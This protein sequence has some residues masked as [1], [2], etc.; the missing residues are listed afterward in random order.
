MSLVAS[1]T[2]HGVETKLYVCG[3]KKS[4]PALLPKDVD[5]AVFFLRKQDRSSSAHSLDGYRDYS[6]DNQV[7]LRAEILHVPLLGLNSPPHLLELCEALRTVF[8]TVHA[9]KESGLATA[10]VAFICKSGLN[11]SA[12]VA[13]CTAL[14]ADDVAT[15][16]SVERCVTSFREARPGCFETDKWTLVHALYGLFS[17]R[18]SLVPRA[19][20]L[21]KPTKELRA[22]YWLDLGTGAGASFRRGRGGM[23]RDPSVFLDNVVPETM[24][25]V[26][27]DPSR[28]MLERANLEV[29]LGGELGALEGARDD[30]HSSRSKAHRYAFGVGVEEDALVAAEWSA[31]A[32]EQGWRDRAAFVEGSQDA[33][34]N[35]YSGACGL[36][37]S[38]FS[39][40]FSAR[41]LDLAIWNVAR[42]LVEG[43]LFVVL[44]PDARFLRYVLNHPCIDLRM[45]APCSPVGSSRGAAAGMLV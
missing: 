30:K 34:P 17:D 35:T 19:R 9:R 22:L 28:A 21:W 36:V 31:R 3:I 6:R 26:G 7:L 14:L 5:L 25:R 40:H 45:Q 11:R 27:I 44:F 42:S 1:V 41:R 20:A 15:P 38:V 37:T 43:G 16:D 12:F 23:R 32:F 18:H 33:I 8:G 24:P 4:E 29:N 13:A 10:K 2:I 39:F